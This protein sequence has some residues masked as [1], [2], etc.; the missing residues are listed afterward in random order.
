M[1][2]RVYVSRQTLPSGQ[3][4]K[5]ANKSGELTEVLRYRVPRG[6]VWKFDPEK[7]LRGFL[8]FV[9]TIAS[10]GGAG[11][12][13]FETTH[14]PARVYS[15]SNDHR[16]G[17]YQ[18]VY[19][20][21]DGAACAIV[22]VADHADGPTYSITATVAGD[23]DHQVCYVPYVPG[24]L[25]VRV[26]SPRGHGKLAAAVYMNDLRAFHGSNQWK[27]AENKINVD[28]LLPPDFSIVFLVNSEVIFGWES[29]ST[30]NPADLVFADMYIP[31]IEVPEHHFYLP[32]EAGG[33][34]GAE[35]RKRA[36]ALLAK[37]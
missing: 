26:E 22:A 20:K 9:E 4:T 7:P 25:E 31:V 10:T 32:E 24:F 30:T 3:V 12:E 34:E 37:C 35:L 8:A 13:V 15:P 19:A 23:E 2:R 16:D 28:L 1:R 18:R 27:S 33:N 14:P 36:D 29:G 17:D 11:D 6:F 5:G 21:D